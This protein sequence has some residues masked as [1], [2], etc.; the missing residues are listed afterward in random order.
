MFLKQ[1]D[2]FIY[3]VVKKLR[4]EGSRHVKRKRKEE[5]HM[6]TKEMKN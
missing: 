1:L 2:F 5:V 3:F 4:C 6:G